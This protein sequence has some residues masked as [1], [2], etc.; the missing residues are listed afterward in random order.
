M[1]KQLQLWLKKMVVVVLVAALGVTMT[2]CGTK[3][4]AAPAASGG[5]PKEGIQVHGHWTIDVK[6]PDGTLAEHR[7][8]E[9][10]L[11]Q[12]QYEGNYMLTWLLSREKTVGA[13]EIAITALNP[14]NSPFNATSTSPP[15]DQMGIDGHIDE[16]TSTSARSSVFKNLTVDRP[17]TGPNTG[18]LV[19]SGTATAMRDGKIERVSTVLYLWTPDLPPSN[20][21]PAGFSDYKITQTDLASAVN[22]NADQQITVTVT[23][24]FS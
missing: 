22:L 5:G 20:V 12:G 8:F 23:I 21:Y 4:A 1:E 2:G 24:S 17:E 11:A 16:S 14:D 13:W 19:L 7:E 6:N 9:N 10:A 15:Y 3:P 18:K